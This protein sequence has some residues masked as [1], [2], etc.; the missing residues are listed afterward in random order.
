MKKIPSLILAN[1]LQIPVLSVGTYKLDPGTG[2][3]GLLAQALQ[4]GFSAVDTAEHYGNEIA[5]GKAVVESGIARENLQI[6]TK[7]WNK[8][9]GYHRTLEAFE[10]SCTRLG[11]NPDILLIHWPCPMKG[12]FRET[13]KALQEIYAKGLVK[14]IGVSNFKVSHLEE[15]REM[16]GTAPMINQIEM[17]PFFIDHAMLEYCGRN[18]IAV[19]A[20]SPLLRGKT[21]IENPLIRKMADR[22]E[23]TSA[24]LAIRYLTQYGTQVVVK[25]SNVQHLLE[26]ADIFRF[27]I[28]S[29]DAEI[30]RT[31]NTGKRV[32]QDPDEY[33]L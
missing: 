29:E 7:I 15:L 9:H 10:E 24:Q 2:T 32:F 19:G 13:W 26:N 17:H 14:A 1:G 4:N 20:W 11:S 28:S 30:L 16:G 18:R 3:G 12:L 31:L 25:S 8:D 23:C 33:Y 6:S 21:V 22:Y 27:E 5:V